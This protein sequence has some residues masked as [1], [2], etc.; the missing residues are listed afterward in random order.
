MLET[1]LQMSSG[2]FTQPQLEA[3]ERDVL[4]KLQWHLNP[5]T[6]HMFVKYFIMLYIKP[7]LDECLVP[8]A[9]QHEVMNVAL[10]LSELSVL[11]YFFVSKR[12]ST[13]AKAAIQNALDL[14]VSSE[15]RRRINIDND[16]DLDVPVGHDNQGIDA[17]DSDVVQSCCNVLWVLH[18]YAQGDEDMN[19]YPRGGRGNDNNVGVINVARD[20][21]TSPVSVMETA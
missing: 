8:I 9:K 6:P 15:C 18:A 21:D 14:V 16:I 19:D 5:P 1:M 17:G 13:V 20:C 7:I 10:Y 2:R 4:D 11:P 3:M 12:P